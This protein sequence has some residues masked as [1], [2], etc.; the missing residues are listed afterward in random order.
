M[1]TGNALLNSLVGDEDSTP[2]T[3]FA[4]RA[5]QTP[6]RPFLHWE[7]SSWTYGAAQAEISQAAGLIASI[8]VTE[9]VVSYLGNRPEA[10]WAWLG[11]QAAGAVHVPLHRGH[12]GEV[13]R[14][15]LARSR[16]N[17]LITAHEALRDLPPLSP[18]G[19]DHVILVDEGLPGAAGSFPCLLNVSVRDWAEVRS[20]TPISGVRRDPLEPASIL[21][22]SGTTGRSKAVVLPGNMFARGAA[23]VAAGLELDEADVIHAW[24]PLY[25]VAG[26]LDMVL[27]LVIAGGAVHL[28]PTFSRTRF[29]SE[30][31]EHRSSVFIGFTTLLELLLREPQ[32]TAD[33]NTSLRAGIIGHVPARLRRSFEERFGVRLLDVYGMTE[34]EPIALPGPGCRPPDGACGRSSPD[35]ELAI[36][37]DRGERMAPG[38]T[39]EIIARPRRAGVMMIGY[40]GDPEATAESLRDGWLHTGDAGTL[41]SDGFLYFL[42]RKKE[43]IRRRGENISP[44]ELELIVLTHD[45]VDECAAVP[46]PSP[47]GEDDVKIVITPRAGSTLNPAALHAWCAQRMA[48]FMVPRFIGVVA[49]LPRTDT[50]KVQ[51]SKL[52][53][54]LDSDFD[55]D[56]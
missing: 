43:I 2:A 26:Q 39:G 5:R 46:V 20:A 28:L 1:Q 44:L 37:N 25:H 12:R 42:E 32:R 22:T 23:H 34:A 47:V 36:S 29:W 10:I 33:L 55:A 24:L 3:V 31:D 50:G 18:L 27:P 13:L 52:R 4:E 40:E 35:F 54:V 48:K 15:M 16:S 8:G 51:R 6:E 21:F 11:T 9:R 38:G 45:D 19:I 17:L 56:R 41:D 14:D 53:R 7:G 30:V 49:A